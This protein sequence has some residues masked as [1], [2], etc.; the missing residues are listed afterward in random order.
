[1]L[2][3]RVTRGK[4]VSIR[5]PS[6]EDATRDHCVDFRH[7]AVSIRAPSGEDATCSSLGSRH[8]G[9]FQS[10]RPR[11][12]T[13]LGLRLHDTMIYRFQSARPR[14]RTRLSTSASATPEWAFQSARPRVRTRPA[15]ACHYCRARGF[16]PRAL[17]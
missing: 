9:W 11:V 1:M 6:G 12:R 16:N 7:H 13:R 15:G 5:A 14:V 10:A 3:L 2:T 4:L 8:A 17:G